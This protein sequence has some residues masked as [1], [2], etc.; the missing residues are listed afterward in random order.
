MFNSVN[1][2][3]YA[4]R[5]TFNPDMACYPGTRLHLLSVIYEWM[6]QKSYKQPILWLKGLFGTGKSALSH[7]VALEAL[8]QKV[9]ASTFFMTPGTAPRDVVGPSTPS[10]NMPSID[11]LV[12]T[13][14]RDLSGISPL[15][16]SAIGAELE[17]S[18]RLLTAS[19]IEQLDQLFYPFL[20]KLQQDGIFLWVIDGFDEIIR[21]DRE[22]FRGRDILESLVKHGP[23]L[24]HSNFIIFI[25][26]RPFQNHPF[27]QF[28]GHYILPLVLDLAASENAEDM[29]TIAYSELQTIA[30]QRQS[31]FTLPLRNS[32]IATAF[33]DKAS[34]LPLWLKIV[35]NFLMKSLDPNKA[36]IDL[37]K[38]DIGPIAY[39]Q[40]INETYA[41]VITAQID[42]TDPDNQRYLNHVVIVLLSLQRPVPRSVL[43]DLVDGAEDLPVT[44]IHSVLNA[45]HPLL[46]GLDN[47]SP[48][49]FIHLSLHDF[50]R[51]SPTFADLIQHVPAPRDFDSGHYLLLAR[52]LNILQKQLQD[53]QIVYEMENG[54]IPDVPPGRARISEALLYSAGAWTHH[55][56]QGAA[57]RFYG[58]DVL[59]SFLAGNFA[60]WLEFH[61]C[62]GSFLFSLEFLESVQV[63][64]Y[65]RFYSAMKLQSVAD[66]LEKI[67]SRLL[68]S[69]RFQ[70]AALASSQAVLSWRLKATNSEPN[71]HL[72]LSLRTLARAQLEL[73]QPSALIA[74]EEVVQIYYAL[75]IEQPAVFNEDLARALNHMFVAF[76]EAGK[77]EEALEASL[78]SVAIY[79][80]LADEQ[81]AVFNGSFALALNNLSIRFTA[82]GKKDAAFEASQQ[83][84]ELYNA[85]AV[86]QPALFNTNHAIA[87]NNLR[88]RFT[89]ARTREEALEAS[90]QS[91]EF[92]RELAAERPVVFNDDL[93]LALNNLSAVF[94]ETG[95]KEEAL[96]T[97]QHSVELYCKLAAERPIVFNSALALALNNLS[98][99]F[100]AVGQR[101][102]AFEASQQSVVRYRELA[103]QRPAVF[104][105]SLAFALNT[106]S[107]CFYDAGMNEEAFEAGQQSVELYRV[108]AV[109]RPL[110]INTLALLS[111]CCYSLTDGV[112]REDP[113]EVHR[114][115]IEVYRPMAG[116]RLL[117]SMAVLP[118]TLANLFDNPYLS[119]AFLEAHEESKSSLTRFRTLTTTIWDWRFAKCLAHFAK[120]AWSLRYHTMAMDLLE[121]SISLYKGLADEQP[122]I[123]QS[124]LTALL[125]LWADWK[126]EGSKMPLCPKPEISYGSNIEKRMSGV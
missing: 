65:M 99:F 21:R 23:K 84:V 83:S 67:S 85:L 55:I 114:Q 81:P 61:I 105:S 57:N 50:F 47:N 113:F 109:E 7:S 97:S 48:V 6:K 126:R 94:F 32:T 119:N 30:R 58:F 66:T 36:L 4:E 22:G 72:A 68:H 12:S 43:S 120:V 93:A 88:I 75:A 27:E 101:E 73:R 108:L 17:A 90:Q 28:S 77:T 82:A 2:L 44:V 104:N 31:D 107:I 69:H 51:D 95:K 59:D 14:L 11:N 124:A 33:R 49:E 111:A 56:T 86:K 3:P 80:N 116:E 52:A 103:A 76:F 24:R 70:E 1:R 125:I 63:E 112:M 79:R 117:Y 26:S 5:A 38:P 42:L 34:G 54:S 71:S 92:Y 20:T 115:S 9:L 19:P 91:V 45:L 110:N 87:L 37:I 10:M 102:G 18:P 41:S 35:R 123:Y 74:S 60:K 25:T 53:D 100:T 62:F 29:D 118:C 96:R 106:L 121:E 15:F 122:W 64:S 16:R 40:R 46:L 13:L 39:R 98:I 78:K 89:T 8:S